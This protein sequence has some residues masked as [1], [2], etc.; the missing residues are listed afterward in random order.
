MT[1][2]DMSTQNEVPIILDNGHASSAQRISF[3][4]TVR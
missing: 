4:H 3:F 2:L 1:M